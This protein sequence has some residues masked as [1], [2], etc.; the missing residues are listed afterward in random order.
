M[1]VLIKA[2]FK[3][4]PVLKSKGAE[5]VERSVEHEENVLVLCQES[6]DLFEEMVGLEVSRCRYKFHVVDD[7]V[8]VIPDY[9]GLFK[10]HAGIHLTLE[11]IDETDICNKVLDAIKDGFQIIYVHGDL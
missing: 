11:T 10:S 1:G 7:V 9:L 4:K 2:N 6:L 5:L 8:T 3:N